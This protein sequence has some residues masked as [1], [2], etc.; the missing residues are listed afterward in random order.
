MMERELTKYGHALQV[1]GTNGDFCS[2]LGLLSTQFL[3]GDI[4]LI[5]KGSAGFRVLQEVVHYPEGQAVGVVVYVQVHQVVPHDVGLGL[6]ILL[7]VF[8]SGLDVVGAVFT[9]EKLVGSR[10][11]DKIFQGTHG[12]GEEHLGHAQP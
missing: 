6:L 9:G 4:D 5:L 7:H 11:F 10:L 3:K 1:F 12:W 2:C 8:D